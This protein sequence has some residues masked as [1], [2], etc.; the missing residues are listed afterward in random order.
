[1]R[2]N[3]PL[4]DDPWNRHIRFTSSEGGV[5]GESVVNLSGLRRDATDAVLVPQ[6]EGQAVPDISTW[7][8][9]VSSGVDDIARW[10]DFALDQLSSERFEI[11]KRSSAGN[12]ASWLSGPGFGTRASGG[13]YLGGATA[14]G[15][16]FGLKGQWFSDL[17]RQ[18][19][20]QMLIG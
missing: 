4:S 16:A 19:C 15:A 5:F 2:F 7:P 13:G 8:T 14:G 18:R 11:K 20:W 6:F 12:K 3:V 9:T 10:G 1:L 17:W